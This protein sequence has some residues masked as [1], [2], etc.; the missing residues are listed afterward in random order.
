MSTP[1]N[2][3]Q[4]SIA[5]AQSVVSQGPYPLS[6]WG[7]GSTLGMILTT[8]YEA[9]KELFSLVGYTF[10]GTQGQS[11]GLP[12]LTGKV[13][14]SPGSASGYYDAPNVAY[15]A[16]QG[17]PGNLLN[18]SQQQLPFSLDGY[19]LPINTA[20]YGQALNYI[21]QI[22][23]MF[24]QGP[25]NLATLGNIYPFIGT[26]VPLGFALCNGQSLP[27]SVYSALYTLIGNAYGSGVGMTSFNLPNLNGTVPIGA[28]GEYLV[29]ETVGSTATRLMPWSLGNG[30]Y[31]TLQT[32][33]TSLALNY[34]I[35]TTGSLN[36]PVSYA[37]LLGE[38][39]LYAGTRPQDGWVVCNGQ[40]LQ[41]NQYSELYKLIGTT[42]GGDG[43]T[44]FAVPDL[45]D[46][47]IVGSGAGLP[48]GTVS[49]QSNVSLTSANYP[50]IVV[51]IPGVALA[52]DTGAVSDL[53][54]SNANLTLSS[55]WPDAT[56]QYSTD[57]KTWTG[58]FKPV[59]GVN[60]VYVRQIDV[61]GQASQAAHS[62]TFTLDTKA[63]ISPTVNIEYGFGNL[64]VGSGGAGTSSLS[65]NLVLS[66]VEAGAKLSYS[67]DGGKTWSD[68]FQAV[69]GQNSVQVRQTDQA[70]NVSA[71][72]AP[73]IFQMLSDPAQ[74]ANSQI[75]TLPSGGHEIVT[76][77]PGV[78]GADVATAFVDTVLHNLQ[79]ALVL[80]DHV[81]N[82]V[83]TGLGGNNT[84]TANGDAN[85]FDVQSGSWIIKGADAKDTIV[86][87]ANSSDFHVTETRPFTIIVEGNTL[88]VTVTASASADAASAFPKLQFK[89][90]ALA[91]TDAASAK[92]LFGLYAGVLGRAPDFAGQAAWQHALDQGASLTRVA[93]AMVGSTEYS[94]RYGTNASTKDFV[95]H[96]YENALH[97]AVDSRGLS[98]WMNAIDSHAMTMGE[99]AVAIT[100][101]AE[102]KAGLPALVL[103]II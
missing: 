36:Q 22:E 3:S 29:G 43:I 27:I 40:L 61:I 103:Q 75:T 83:L 92:A 72:S 17:N 85:R 93:D 90:V 4:P 15:G 1:I 87:N 66:G 10:G 101:S 11:F 2:L 96:L 102:A 7:S 8:A 6:G 88:P 82:I 20:Q 23:G 13:I 98:G 59:E 94:D 45:R 60:I 74:K 71:A 35:S 44:T 89:D 14:V 49:G 32:M 51:P 62:L 57:G 48:I 25:D 42:F 67:I 73:A 100:G 54:T 53:V 64:I 70:G 65:G 5:L 12:D 34:I 30:N 84:I 16:I 95:L 58:S 31:G 81:E 39:T 97:R 38:I 78:I 80:P 56:V 99:V 26:Q 33:Q 55:I 50:A 47:T 24:P 76:K 77:T 28:G 79:S 91:A 86:F 9:N 18:L 68:H 41:I 21:I 19:M 52:N 37:P 63:P 46:R 69:F